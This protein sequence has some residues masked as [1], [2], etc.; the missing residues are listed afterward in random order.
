MPKIIFTIQYELTEDKREEY[1]KTIRELKNI[2]K[3]DG[4]ENYSVYEM[5][6]KP[7]HFQEQYTFSSPEAFE[8]FDDNNDERTN[9]LINKIAEMS[10]DRSTKYNTFTEVI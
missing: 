3:I 5:K 2:L 8:S 4:L 6:G 10:V 1:L 9:I 7:N